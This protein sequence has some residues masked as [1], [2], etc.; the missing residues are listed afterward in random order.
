MIDLEKRL[1]AK[2]EE[3][4][5]LG[6]DECVEYEYEDAVSTL[7]L[8]DALAA[9]T[10]ELNEWKDTVRTNIMHVELSKTQAALDVMRDGL[11]KIADPRKRDHSEPDAYTTLGCVMNIADEALA[12]AARILKETS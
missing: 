2:A 12:H 1:R 6:P 7:K 10:K 4:I 8:L 5:E 11:D 9:V 3:F